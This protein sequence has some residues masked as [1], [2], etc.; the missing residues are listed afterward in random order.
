M[1][2]TMFS[3]RRFVFKAR[4]SSIAHVLMILMTLF[5]VADDKIRW[6]IYTLQKS[7]LAHMG[8]A[9]W[10]PRKDS[11]LGLTFFSK[12]NFD[13][14]FSLTWIPTVPSPVGL[15]IALLLSWG[16]YSIALMFYK[17]RPIRKRRLTSAIL[18]SLPILGV[19]TSVASLLPEVAAL[20][21]ERTTVIPV[22]VSIN[23]T[24]KMIET[25]TGSLV[26]LCS[27]RAFVVPAASFPTAPF[28]ATAHSTPMQGQPWLFQVET[29]KANGRVHLLAVF[30]SEAAATSLLATIDRAAK[31]A[32]V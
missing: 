29:L 8:M 13:G 7:A 27:N 23:P 4:V 15:C 1:S 3:T 5:S 9:P 26:R 25:P 19:L 24:L 22:R 28:P 16:L 17:A 10:T 30:G 2:A 21:N 20:Q 14:Q 31:A 18:L 32:C 6:Q 12:T 11:I